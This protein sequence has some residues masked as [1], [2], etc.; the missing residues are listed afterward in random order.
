M[1]Y[2]ISYKICID[3]K[4]KK[5]NTQEKKFVVYVRGFSINHKDAFLL[6]SPIRNISGGKYDTL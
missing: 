4:V 5:Q 2:S 1:Y 3:F 6:S